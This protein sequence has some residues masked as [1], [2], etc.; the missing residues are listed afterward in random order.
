[1]RLVA[2][3]AV[4][5]VLHSA[6]ARAQQIVGYDSSRGIHYN[7]ASPSN[8][9][10]L[11]F[12]AHPA[13]PW[14]NWGSVS[15]QPITGAVL[16]ALGPMFFRIKEADGL[17]NPIY[18]TDSCVYQTESTFS[19]AGTFA[20]TSDWT[21]VHTRLIYLPRLT[22]GL[23]G[24]CDTYCADLWWTTPRSTFGV[25]SVRY[26]IGTNASTSFT[27]P[28]PSGFDEVAHSDE[29]TMSVTTSGWVSIEFQ[30]R[31][32]SVTN[33]SMQIGNVSIYTRNNN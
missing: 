28:M 5:A 15:D 19:G 14:T 18:A 27:A 17:L 22:R 7:G 13:G 6:N 1:M 33:A 8:F 10:T 2:I 25:Y 4:L 24:V 9:F 16:T 21:T 32:E 11:E 12:A 23:R 29:M 30:T 3:L 31:T 26:K 20:L